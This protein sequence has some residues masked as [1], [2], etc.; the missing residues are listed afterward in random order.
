MKQI[1]LALL[2]VLGMSLRADAQEN[3]IEATISGQLEAFRADNFDAAFGYAAP[4]IQRI[5]GN[6]RNF[7]AMVRQGY[8]VMTG[9]AE[10][11]FIAKRREAG[12]LWQRVQFSA[13]DG[14]VQIFDYEMILTDAGWRIGAVQ[15]VPLPQ[16][17]A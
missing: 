5:F 12:V 16:V 15:R 3:S 17:S 2:I 13:P 10:A 8:S 9:E 11:R 4:G 1:V 14:R 6:A 7:E